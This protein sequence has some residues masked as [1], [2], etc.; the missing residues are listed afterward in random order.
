MATK[1]NP[2]LPALAPT[3]ITRLTPLGIR[4]VVKKG[5]KTYRYRY[6]RL[7]VS[8]FPEVVG[9][10]RIRVLIASPDFSTQPVLITARLVKK[11]RRTLGFV[12]DSPYQ[13]IVEGYERNGYVAVLYIETLEREQEGGAP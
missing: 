12:I 2:T 13:K 3:I 4:T 8:V 10:R 11:G 6:L 7:D 1:L 9:A 5:A